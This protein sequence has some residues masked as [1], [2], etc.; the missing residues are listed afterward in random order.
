MAA[1]Q[2]PSEGWPDGQKPAPGPALPAGLVPGGDVASAGFPWEG[3]TFDHHGTAFAGDDGTT[4]DAVASAVAR[5]R[6][7]GER[8][9]GG[10]AAALRELAEAHADA[11]AAFGAERFLVA[12]IAEAGELGETP[13]GRIVEKTQELSIVTVAAPDGR[14]VLPIFT[15]VETMQ[16]WHPEA[17]PIPVPGAQA[18]LAAAQENTDLVMI[19][20]AT[21]EREYGVRRT[22]LEAF[23]LGNRVLPGWA[24]PEVGEAFALTI[25]G[26]PDVLGIALEPGDPLARLIAPE[27]RV[28]L[29]LAPGLDR[30]ALDALLARMQQRW[31]ESAL[32]ADRVDSMT[33][34]LRGPGQG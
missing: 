13:E 15:S 34:S 4:P 21:P 5:V 6:D 11:V 31:A 19:D 8:S 2:L 27:I 24:D 33:V 30:A 10:D 20:A 25:A 26:E 28:V 29:T 1:K 22:A 32:I 3:R 14:R 16:R 7:A 9:S 18:A 17:R 23:A 12:L